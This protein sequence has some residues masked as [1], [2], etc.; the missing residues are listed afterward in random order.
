MTRLTE[1]SIGN[2]A[3]LEFI[4]E[5]AQ[6]SVRKS[7][8]FDVSALVAQTDQPMIKTNQPVIEKNSGGSISFILLSLFA[9]NIFLRIKIDISKLYRPTRGY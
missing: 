4:A 7:I 3:T 2:S 9:L 8:T 6:H 5:D 1:P